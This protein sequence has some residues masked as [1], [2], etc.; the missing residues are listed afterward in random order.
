M[1]ELSV[2]RRELLANHMVTPVFA[3]DAGD[4]H[5]YAKAVRIARQRVSRM[6]RLASC[7]NRYASRHA[8]QV[9][10]DESRLMCIAAVRD[11]TMA[12]DNDPAVSKWGC[13]TRE[14]IEDIRRRA[15]MPDVAGAG[16][17]AASPK[18]KS[19]KRRRGQQ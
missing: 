9:M 6:G 7:A 17:S 19:K 16:G 4:Q 5:A 13:T 10:S 1:L 2:Q 15:G 12:W 18:A 11:A 8:E 3:E 14:Q